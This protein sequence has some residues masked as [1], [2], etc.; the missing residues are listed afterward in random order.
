MLN[1]LLLGLSLLTACAA[2]QSAFPLPPPPP[3]RPVAEPPLFPGTAGQPGHVG[4]M[5]LPPK[6]PHKRVLPQTPETRKVPGLWAAAPS[7]SDGTFSPALL[8]EAFPV[9]ID[10]STPVDYGVL[11]SCAAN[12][13]LAADATGATEKAAG[14]TRDVR[15]CLAARLLWMCVNHDLVRYEEA[16][17]KGRKDLHLMEAI[18]ALGRV[19][20]RLTVSSRKQCDGVRPT[21][22]E[23]TLM[24]AVFRQWR[25]D[26]D[27]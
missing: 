13:R 1:L 9:L 16:R 11:N 18:D 8:L 26:H 14:V 15:R 22:D 19:E 17:D 3:L 23:T 10:G 12:L 5:A 2:N 20:R 7:A 21:H 6:S 27:V 24:N 4:P 25:E